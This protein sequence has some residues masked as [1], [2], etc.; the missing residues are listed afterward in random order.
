MYVIATIPTMKKE[1]SMNTRRNVFFVLLT[2]LLLTGCGDEF[3]LAPEPEPEP[4]PE[5][6]LVAT[7]IV[8]APVAAQV[9]VGETVQLEA[10]V[11][12]QFGDEIEDAEVTWQSLIPGV[13]SV[14]ED[15]LVTTT[16]VGEG[17]IAV[18]HANLVT[19][20][21]IFVI[22]PTV[23]RIEIERCEVPEEGLLVGERVVCAVTP[24]DGRDNE[25]PGRFAT[26]TSLNS[27]VARLCPDA[28]CGEGVAT[29]SRSH[30]EPIEIL[31]FSWG[32]A[33][34]VVDVDGV[35]DTITIQTRVEPTTR[36]DIDLPEGYT[37]HV[38]RRDKATPAL[39]N[40]RGEPQTLDGRTLTW[41]SSNPE[42]ARIDQEGNVTGVS[43]GTTR[44]SLVVEVG[45]T[46]PVVGSIDIDFTRV[47]VDSV[48]V[49]PVRSELQVGERVQLT[50][51]AFDADGRALNAVELD[52]R[53]SMW[54]WG[55]AERVIVPT[56]GDTSPHFTRSFTAVHPGAVR[57]RVEI[58]GV[59]G[60]AGIIV[61]R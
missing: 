25:I 58:D 26:W 42:V 33:T 13:A 9:E 20:S 22:E 6:E 31:S 18:L 12:D 10:V 4:E 17:I 46:P 2:S 16:R 1:I 40:A 48:A 55:T 49:T 15:G 47:P 61:A 11:R 34:V 51:Q 30:E 37:P 14:T 7:S 32:R 53:R 36:V 23:A 19:E 24:Y 39:F 60:I 3:V 54:S 57:I 29:I 8:I 41:S 21:R 5:I 44:I 38:G 50:A 56:P 28:R 27:D 52:G 43:V 45:N 35:S 59:H